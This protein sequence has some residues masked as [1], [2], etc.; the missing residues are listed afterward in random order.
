M[1][2][3]YLVRFVSRGHYKYANLGNVGTGYK[4]DANVKTNAD[5]KRADYYCWEIKTIVI[6]SKKGSALHKDSGSA[7][8][9]TVIGNIPN[10]NFYR[11]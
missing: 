10:A 3:I 4:A 5:S 9:T 6:S 11:S 8:F 1:S 2:F 7:L